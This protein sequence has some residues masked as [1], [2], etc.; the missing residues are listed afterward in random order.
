VKGYPASAGRGT[1]HVRRGGSSRNE[2][3]RLARAGVA[4]AIFRGRTSGGGG[5]ERQRKATALR[6]RPSAA[7]ALPG[8]GS[9]RRQGARRERFSASALQRFGGLVWRLASALEDT[10]F[11]SA[12]LWACS[13]GATDSSSS[14][15]G[16]LSMVSLAPCETFC[17][18]LA[19][20]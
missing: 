7:I 20:S 12:S 3:A 4:S 9:V 18:V 15:S 11:L 16:S 6:R 10:G 2:W 17:A 13:G 19:S 8:A 1:C 14:P 5:P